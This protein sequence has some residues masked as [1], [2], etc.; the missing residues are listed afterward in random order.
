LAGLRDIAGAY[1][2]VRIYG[3]SPDSP[4][5]SR[6]FA[7]KVPSDGRGPLGFQLLSD[8][9]SVVIDRYG[10]R[11]PAYAGEK[12]NGVP[13]PSVFVLDQQGRIRWLKIE[14]DYRERPTNEEVAAALD[15]FE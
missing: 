11:D 5:E 14:N 13:R 4:Q 10:L 3:I 7:K 15:S 9:G 1:R 2:D 6:E 8:A 12:I